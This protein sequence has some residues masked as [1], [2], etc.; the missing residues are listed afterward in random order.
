MYLSVHLCLKSW[1]LDIFW[2]NFRE[3]WL[4]V[5]GS[6]RI[7]REASTDYLDKLKV[8][9]GLTCRHMTAR[10]LQKAGSGSAVQGD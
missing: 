1:Q 8:V 7:T 3:D 5:Q 4:E 6:V 2:G 10:G 9:A